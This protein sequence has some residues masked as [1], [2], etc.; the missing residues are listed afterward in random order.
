MCCIRIFIGILFCLVS[1]IT[2]GQ[3]NVTA[4][5]EPDI[6]LNYD[7]ATNYSHN[8]KISQRSYIY[9]DDFRFKARQLDIS[10]FSKFKIR[11]N[12][13]IALGLQYRFRSTFENDRENELRITQQYNIT[14]KSANIRFGNRFRT[15]QRIT[16]SLTTHRFRYRLA[17]DAPLNG[18]KLDVGE[19]YFVA[20][21]ESLLS[22]ARQNRPEYDQRISAH[23]GWL[24][25]K[26]TKLQLGTEYRAENFAHRTE[27]V[28]F[29]LASLVLSL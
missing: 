10:H 11:Y 3:N 1:N 17:L 16:P 22:V 4:Y 20:S 21:T 2:V 14:R 5:F 9:D 26:E 18:E 27:H 28:L 19:A 8:F 23:I 6:S 29:M 24:L 7:L 15:E 12:Q 13:S 25:N